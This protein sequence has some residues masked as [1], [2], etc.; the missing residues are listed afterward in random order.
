MPLAASQAAEAATAEASEAAYVATAAVMPLAQKTSTVYAHALPRRLPFHGGPPMDEAFFRTRISGTHNPGTGRDLFPD[1]TEEQRAAFL[2]EKEDLFRRLAADH[3]KPVEG[4]D[5]LCACGYRQQ[6]CARPQSQTHH[7]RMRSRCW[8]RWA[9]PPSLS[10]LLSDPSVPAPSPSP[11]RTSRPCSGSACG[12]TN[13]LRVRPFPPWEHRALSGGVIGAIPT[14]LSALTRLRYL[15]LSNNLLTGSVPDALSTLTRLAYLYMEHNSLSGTFPSSLCNLPLLETL[16]LHH[17]TF[18]GA[19][20]DAISGLSRMRSLYLGN[21]QLLGPLPSTISGLKNLQLLYMPSNQL[22]GPLPSTI[23]KL[24]SLELMHLSHNQIDGAIPSTISALTNLCP[25]I[26]NANALNQPLPNAFKKLTYLNT[27]DLRWNDL[28]GTLPATLGNMT[29]LQILY[30]DTAELTCGDGGSCV[31]HQVSWS[32][33]CHLCPG[34][35]SS[36]TEPPLSQLLL[37][38]THAF[39]PPILLHSV[40]RPSVPSLSSP[41]PPRLTVLVLSPTSALFFPSSPFPPPLHP[42]HKP[43]KPCKKRRRAC[44]RNACLK[45]KRCM[46]FVRSCKGY[47]CF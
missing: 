25:I 29:N 17:N 37:S 6:G 2:D 31:V 26:L 36:C 1:C 19:L 46:P 18:D 20:P 9:S 38:L 35:C 30:V 14:A 4:L 47:K 15:D 10:T 13:A 33:F 39:M 32:A 23:G 24:S 40:A 22:T 44:P 5:R 16:W 28:T 8:Q 21:N 41:P 3:T 12:R 45:G 34:F 43:D 42:V 11:T 7:G 27:L